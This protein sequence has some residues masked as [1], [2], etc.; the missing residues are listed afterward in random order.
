MRMMDLAPL[1]RSSI[2]FDRLFDLLDNAA[3]FEHPK[4]IRPT[5]SRRP[6]KMH[7]ASRSRWQASHPK[8]C[9]SP[10]SRMS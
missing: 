2:G 8:I 5:T 3:Q 1:S 10:P 7:T 4:T 6:V 9:R